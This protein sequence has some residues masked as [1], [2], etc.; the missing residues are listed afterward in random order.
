MSK[1]LTPQTKLLRKK[2]TDDSLAV[3][4][5]NVGD[6][7][8]IVVRFPKVDGRVSVAVVDCYDA[9]KTCAVIEDLGATHIEFVCA[10]HPHF[11]HTKGILALLEWAISKGI[12]VEQFWDSGFR[13][14]SKTHYDIIRFLQE[15]KE[16][17]VVRPTSGYETICSL[18]RV[19]VL[20]PSIYLK[21]RYDTFGTN[22]NNASIVLKLEYPPQDIA[23]AYLPEASISDEELARNEGLRR[24]T[25]VL[26]GDAQFDAWARITQ[27]F[28]ELVDTDNRLALIDSKKREFR[29]LR[30]QV[31]KA[32][33]HMS[34]HGLTLEVM[35]ALQPRFTIASCASRSK[36]GFPH[37]LTVLA[38]KDLQKKKKDA[39][40]RFTGHR[41]RGL[42]GGTIA[43]LCRGNGAMP[44]VVP[45]GEGVGER[46]PI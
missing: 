29:P 45:L 27:E 41:T 44:V 25:F 1:T 15:R 22:I 23:P 4:V 34:K 10:T 32:P 13:H 40:L 38:V 18:V 19:L 3:F 39:G 2:L 42:G 14:V 17:R 16:I 46:A 28:P 9:E 26:A 37:E 8:A 11:D 21:N 12:A 30:C 20:S 36:H 7:D 35:E 24:N 33:H 5:L 31:L 6:G 43:A